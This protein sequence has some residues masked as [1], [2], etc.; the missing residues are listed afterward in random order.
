LAVAA[1]LLNLAVALLRALP[2]ANLYVNGG[3][4]GYTH[5]RAA[6][7]LKLSFVSLV[8]VLLLAATLPMAVRADESPSTGQQVADV[9]ASQIGARYR[10]GGS[11]PVGFDC[12]GFVSWVFREFDLEVP[13]NEAG[14]LA[15]G[16]AVSPTDLQPGDVLVFAN[17]Y[18]RGLSHT[19]I[20]LGEGQF[21]HAA[22]ERRGVMV[23]A[24]WSDYWAVRLVGASRP[25]A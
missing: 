21:V 24:L 3:C 17:T 19:G 14:Q 5:S 2:G 7:C 4:M 9:A 12:T 13:R 1:V 20:Y 18:R 16:P 25:L 11:S 22:D 10:W 8:A 15:A 23:S 6:L